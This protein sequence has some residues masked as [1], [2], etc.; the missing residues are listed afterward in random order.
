M[1]EEMAKFAN[2]DARLLEDLAG[3][4]LAY[5]VEILSC[6]RSGEVEIAKIRELVPKALKVIVNYLE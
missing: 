6:G 3:W 2:Y 5:E 1:K 4:L